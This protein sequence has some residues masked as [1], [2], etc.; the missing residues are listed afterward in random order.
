MYNIPTVKFMMNRGFTKEQAT[1]IRKAIE[2]YYKKYPFNHPRPTTTL[3]KISEML[4]LCG[5]ESIPKGNNEKSPE[6]VYVNSGD[7][8]DTT[9]MWINGRFRIGDWGSIF[10]RGNYD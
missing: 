6:I 2:R 4:N 1:F 10:E 5:V 7:T 8:Y 3:N 9:V